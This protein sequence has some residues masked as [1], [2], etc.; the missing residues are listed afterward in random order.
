[1]RPLLVLAL[2][3]IVV[4]YFAMAPLYQQL[5]GRDLMSD[6]LRQQQVEIVATLAELLFP[7]TPPPN[8]PAS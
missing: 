1:M 5:N 3:N 2:Y 8:R 6:T 4:G 7:R